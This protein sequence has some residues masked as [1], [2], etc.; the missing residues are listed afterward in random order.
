MKKVFLLFFV[1]TNMNSYSQNTSAFVEIQ[2]TQNVKKYSPQNVKHDFYAWQWFGFVPKSGPGVFM[3]F[4]QEE[5]TKS[6]SM[7]LLIDFSFSKNRSLELGIALGD[8]QTVGYGGSPL[9]ISGYVYYETKIDKNRAKEKITVMANFYYS[10]CFGMWTQTTALYS[11]NKWFALGL[12]V[13]SGAAIGPRMQINM[14][15]GF[16][17]W[18]AYSLESFHSGTPLSLGISWQGQS[19]TIKK[20]K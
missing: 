13:Q 7:G 18:S 20:K 5:D 14:P 6:V 17:L 11:L 9:C 2:S 8:E 1:I 19:S 16:S 4:S 15:Y 3:Q 10:D 12:H